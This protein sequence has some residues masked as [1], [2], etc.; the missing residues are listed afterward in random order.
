MKDL[1]MVAHA[2]ILCLVFSPTAIA[3]GQDQVLKSRYKEAIER[4][5]SKD[6]E[7]AYE[8][9]F[10]IVRENEHY[11]E[12][13]VLRIA[14]AAI[15]KK[16]GT[17][18][19]QNLIRVAKDYAPLGSNLERD[20]QN[21]INL[22]N[23]TPVIT[24][25][26][27]GVAGPK[28]EIAVSPYVRKRIALVVGIGSFKDSNI[29]PL[30]FT[31]NDARGF[32]EALNKECK[33]DYVKVLIDAQATRELILTEVDNIAKTAQPDDLVVIYIATHGSP[34][35]LDS[36]GVNYI[37]TYD[38]VIDNLYATS[39]KMKDL[40]EDIETRIPAQRVIAFIDTCF[41]GATFKQKP[42]G[43]TSSARG[44]KVQTSGLQ[45][46]S[47]ETRLKNSERSVK[48]KP[49]SANDGRKQQ[50]IG[51]VII[52]SSRQNERAWESDTIK[53]GYFTYYLIQA[54]QRKGAVSIQSL[55]DFLSAEV[56]KAVQRER[57]AEQ[58][59]TMVSSVDGPVKIYI[60]D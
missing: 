13:Q 46:E 58:N 38:S 40:L 16:T 15:L 10:K 57:S 60:K 50:E 4:A 22:L 51:R 55:Y 56:P 24:P 18:G 34:E 48:I 1:K 9:A 59:P 39:Y 19:P 27:V 42:N 26:T 53:H 30:S 7:R 35:N 41:S 21:M 17:E 3:Y 49:V 25:N 44:L 37:I 54:L 29:N 45:L 36:A 28:K 23:G 32:A 5:Q 8:M 12:A 33:F 2:L 47:I 43:W 31:S 11:Y 20:I 14:L 6:Y 52:A